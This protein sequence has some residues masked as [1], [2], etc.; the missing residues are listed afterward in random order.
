MHHQD[1]LGGGHSQLRISFRPDFYYYF[2]QDS[3]YR[4]LAASECTL[5]LH[6]LCA[7]ML[8]TPLS[9]KM[10]SP[11]ENLR[12]LIQLNLTVQNNSCRL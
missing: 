2:F 3:D 5:G 10:T 12:L 9:L 11:I 6:S 8:L 1:W 4:P 7:Y